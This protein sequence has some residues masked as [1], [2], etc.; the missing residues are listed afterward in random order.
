MIRSQSWDV[1]VPGT[2]RRHQGVGGEQ[3]VLALKIGDILT[4]FG[5]LV[6]R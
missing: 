5:V 6:R 4:L 3:L 1:P 2:L